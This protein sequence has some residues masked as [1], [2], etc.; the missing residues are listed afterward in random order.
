M[1]ATIYDE[2]RTLQI[3]PNAHAEWKEYR[4]NL[5]QLVSQ[6]GIPGETLGIFGVGRGNDLD[7]KKLAE[8]Y[9]K[10]ILFDVDEEAMREAVAFYQLPEEKV[11]L[12]NVDLLGITDEEYRQFSNALQQEVLRFG[13]QTDVE[14]FAAF[15]MD[16][17]QAMYEKAAEKRKD[18]PLEKVDVLV[19]AG[20]HSQINNMPAWLFEVFCQA[21]GKEDMTFYQLVAMEN[22]KLIPELQSYFLQ[23]AN[24]RAIFALEK[25]R[26]GVAG[27]VQGAY[28]GICDLKKRADE[29]TIQILQEM[30]WVWPFDVK[31][32]K[33]YKMGI[34][35]VQPENVKN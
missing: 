4:E 5:T 32:G 24:R 34:Y 3:L 13:Y 26:M 2:L 1:Y 9:G 23:L 14:S 25:E 33:S 27:G 15:A 30:E 35:E 29:K 16:H 28:Q 20:L 11:E 7:L 6:T 12:R 18:L 21:V 8:V 19:A 17:L 10:I 22:D 31:G